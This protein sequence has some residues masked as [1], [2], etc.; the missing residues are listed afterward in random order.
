MILKNFQSGFYAGNESKA[1]KM[2]GGGYNKASLNRLGYNHQSCH[3]S[4][5]ESGAYSVV[6]GAGTTE[7]TVNDYDLADASIMA[8]DKMVSISQS[9]TSSASGGATIM[10]QWQN[11]S[12][13]AITVKEVG[14]AYKLAY[15]AYSKDANILVARKV[16]DTF[17]TIQ[18]NEVYTFAYNIKV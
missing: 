10:T 6:I 15:N 12:G 14:L 7:P 2:N 17:V 18:P 5:T 11:V 3:Y 9:A 1:V 16:L 13:S 4:S 8:S